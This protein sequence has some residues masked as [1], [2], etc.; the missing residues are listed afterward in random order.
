[1]RGLFYKKGNQVERK[2][3]IQIGDRFGRLVVTKRNGYHISPSGD[4]VIM[5]LC[6]CDCGNTTLVRTTHLTHNLTKSCGCLRAEQK[7]TKDKIEESAIKKVIREYKVNAR[8][9]NLEWCLSYPQVREIVTKK[10]Y[11]CGAE[12]SS[13]KYGFFHNGIDRVDNDLGYTPENVVPCCKVCNYAKNNMSQNDFFSW[14]LRVA[15][16]HEKRS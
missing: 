11:Y 3:K 6:Q 12:N 15:E 16:Q 2:T 13:Q 1:M 5:W 14:V 10:C 8:K 4:K 9:R 7:R